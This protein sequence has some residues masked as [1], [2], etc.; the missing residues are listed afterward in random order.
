[1][2]ELLGLI[3]GDGDFPLEIA[4]SARRQGRRVYAVGFHGLTRAELGEVTDELTWLHLGQVEALL[5]S[6]RSA[7]VGD[8]VMAG[9]VDKTHLQ[10]AGGRL[11]LDARARRLLADLPDHRDTSILALLA[12]ALEEQGLALCPQTDWVPHLLLGEGPLG[13]LAPSDAQWRDIHAGWPIA[14]RIAADEVGQCVVV[15]A[16]AVVAVEAM[17]GTDATIRRAASLVGAGTTVVKVARPHQDPRFD[18]PVIGAGTLD[19]LID[20]GAGVLAIEAGATVVLDREAVIRRSN[21]HGIALVGLA[22]AGPTDLS[23]AD[24]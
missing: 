19:G 18:V 7:G 4:R 15:K 16:G 11:R 23:G 6:L 14:R 10:G 13:K 22:P 24:E 1:V 5:G 3:A 2:A 21:R 8:V 17:E 12:S 20:A 9:K